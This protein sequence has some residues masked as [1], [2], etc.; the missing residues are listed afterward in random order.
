MG[1][2]RTASAL[3]RDGDL[4]VGVIAG[5]VVALVM[6]R[7]KGLAW[8]DPY[9]FF[10]YAENLVSGHGW[11]LNAGHSTDNAVTGPLMVLLLATLRVVRVP[12]FASAAII[13]HLST[14][15]AALLGRRALRAAGCPRGGDLAAAL[16]CTCPAFTLMWG[17]ESSLYIALLAAVL[18]MGQVSTRWWALGL[19]IGML[20]LVRPD[21]WLI[22]SLTAT[23]LLASRGET[24]NALRH[25]REFLPPLCAPGVLWS[26]L[27]WAATGS[28]VP[29][30]LSAKSAQGT[31]GTWAVFG[32]WSDITSRWPWGL[33]GMV[34]PLTRTG[35]L[36]VWTVCILVFVG[37]VVV[38]RG[39]A[40]ARPV[41]AL[42]PPIILVAAIYGIVLRVASAPWYWIPPVFGLIVTASVG[43]DA[44]V[45]ST[46]RGR[47]MQRIYMQRIVVSVAVAA[48]CIIG[49]GG[50]RAMTTSPRVEY[51]EIG[52]WLK[53]HT[54]ADATVAI[55]EIGRVSWTSD[56]TII[57][58][59]GL[60]DRRL[61]TFVEK[62]D[63][64]SWMSVTQ[65]DYWVVSRSFIDS[66]LRESPCFGLYFTK[67]HDTTR[68]TIEKRTR[69]I[70][71]TESC[72]IP[73]R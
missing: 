70:P 41:I 50:V 55:F 72:A 8:D 20:A 61:G 66:P 10:R 62:G 71:A 15:A 22:G 9:I 23:I 14:V 44:V 54:P 31:S 46:T 37:L 18:W 25:W 5:L 60:I 43:F 7:Q 13:F 1:G 47:Y 21:A 11:T 45:R 28:P 56:R 67:V 59:L 53:S 68:F 57:D 19:V 73:E 49:Y 38:V 2:R 64:T 36:A 39:R 52:A 4:A 51:D 12:M 58:P 30:T 48:S 32:S 6:W 34:A 35:D 42:V 33:R 3:V 26:G 27:Q 29:A 24:S 63:M 16:V 65:P 69:P 40:G 17:M